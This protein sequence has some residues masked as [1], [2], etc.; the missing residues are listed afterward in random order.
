M[1][2][3]DPKLPGK[4]RGYLT[5]F[6]KFLFFIIALVGV[7]LTILFNMGGSS[8]T[9][10]S[11][12]ENY[13]RELAGGRPAKIAKLNRLSFFPA[14][15]VDFEGLE[16]KET[17]ASSKTIISGEKVKIFVTFWGL[18]IKQMS[19]KALFLENIVFSQGVFGNKKFSIERIFIDHDKGTQQAVIKGKGSLDTEEWQFSLGIDVSGSVGGYSYYLGKV[20]PINMDIGNVHFQGRILEQ[21]SDYLKIDNFAMGLPKP[22]LQGEISFSLLEGKQVKINGRISTEN[23]VIVFKPDLIIDFSTRPQKITGKIEIPD[24]VYEKI[25]GPDSPVELFNRVHEILISGL[26]PKEDKDKNTETEKSEEKKAYLCT[27]NFDVIIEISKSLTLSESQAG[28]L[29]VKAVNKDGKMTLTE[30][31]NKIEPFKGLCSDLE[32]LHYTQNHSRE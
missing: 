8:E 10:K 11:S 13:I 7:L 25:S 23:P 4:E 21:I 22:I 27:Y 17:P 20:R 14:I 2:E 32:M 1:T 18:V 28:A 12:L 6:L 5:A 19:I 3:T 26:S 30:E 15:G 24:L 31:N 9:L 29:E 16:V